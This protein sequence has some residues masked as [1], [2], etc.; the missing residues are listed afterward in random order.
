MAALQLGHICLL[1]NGILFVRLER[2]VYHV[3]LFVRSS[4]HV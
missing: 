1:H 2:T 3:T 4:V